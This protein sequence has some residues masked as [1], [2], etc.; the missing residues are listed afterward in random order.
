MAQ[1][2]L[3]KKAHLCPF[4]VENF[5]FCREGYCEECQIYQSYKKKYGV[6]LP[7]RKA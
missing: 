7:I 3:H 5:V 1:S 2:D 4:C 6:K